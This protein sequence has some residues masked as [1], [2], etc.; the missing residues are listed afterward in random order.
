[1]TVVKGQPTTFR[2]HREMEEPRTVR[3][4]VRLADGADADLEGVAIRVAAVDGNYGD[5]ETLSADKDGSFSFATRGTEIGLFGC[6][7]DGAAAGWTVTTDL[8]S[9]VELTLHP[10]RQLQGQLL[11]AEGEP[12]VGHAVRAIVRIKGEDQSLRGISFSKSF[13]AKTIETTTDEQGLY[14]LQGLPVEIALSIRAERAPGSKDVSIEDV[15]L[16]ANENRPRLVSRIGAK[17]VNDPE[18]PLA[19]RFRDTLR[20]CRA[21]GYRLLLVAG[22]KTEET[23]RFTDF[24]FSKSNNEDLY[25]YMPIV[26]LAGGEDSRR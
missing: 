4:R 20:N 18:R 7:R 19:E 1:M 3:G 12:L 9:P 15:Y 14:T 25:S 6:T 26:V 22:R 16:T 13:E 21:M 5:E 2:L 24:A 10:T 8:D 17:E 23:T 11:D